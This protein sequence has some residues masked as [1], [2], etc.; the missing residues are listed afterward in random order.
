MHL[1]D[2]RPVL[3]YSQVREW[4]RRI[5]EIPLHI[6]ALQAE[7]VEIGRKLEAAKV[8][9]G[10]DLSND[11]VEVAEQASFAVFADPSEQRDDP[12]PDTVLKAVGTLSGAPK[13][14]EIKQWIVEHGTESAAKA[15][16]KPYFYTVLMRHARTGRLIK[17]GD[18]YRLPSSS[19]EGEAGG[20]DPRPAQ[21]L[22]PLET[23]APLPAAAE[24][25]GI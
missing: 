21:S 12:F 8:I 19:P 9:M 14:A 16:A 7:S 11:R 18:G 3:T 25:G 6:A 10:G 2:D 20:G 13:P 4:Q 22:N 1:T 17:E 24:A 23:S 15:A 5:A